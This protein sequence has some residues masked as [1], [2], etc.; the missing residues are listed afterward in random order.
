MELIG[1]VICTNEKCRGEKSVYITSFEEIN[2]SICQCK[3]C[4]A[5]SHVLNIPFKGQKPCVTLFGWTY[6]FRKKTK[7]DY[8]KEE[9]SPLMQQCISQSK[10]S[11]TK[12]EEAN[13]EL[14]PKKGKYITINGI[15]V[16]RSYW[17]FYHNIN[18]LSSSF[19]KLF[20]KL[21]HALL[22]ST[23][24]ILQSST[25][26]HSGFWTLFLIQ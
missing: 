3:Q 16:S 8:Q 26:E 7:L 22:Q 15:I 6:C 20:Y 11:T 14:A 24:C 9:L 1:H 17:L 18:L 19:F 4:K 5:C 23:Q 2:K 10:L 12:A 13:N 25:T 21:K